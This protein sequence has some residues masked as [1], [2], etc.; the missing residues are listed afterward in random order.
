MKEKNGKNNLKIINNKF[1]YQRSKL[2]KK[3]KNCQNK[4]ILSLIK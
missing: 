2:Q 1:I 3:I 4:K